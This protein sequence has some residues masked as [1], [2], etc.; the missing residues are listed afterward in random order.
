M[1]LP[2]RLIVVDS[3]PQFAAWAQPLANQG[4]TAPLPPL[5]L[6][7]LG[8]SPR[9]SPLQLAAD[10]GRLRAIL[11]VLARQPGWRL[12]LA[13]SEQQQLL[14]ILESRAGA[15]SA[16]A[17][18][19]LHFACING[20][21]K[22]PPS[23]GMG[24]PPKTLVLVEDDLLVRAVCRRFLQDRCLVLETGSAADALALAN[25]LPWPVDLLVSDVNL[26]LMDGVALARRWLE[27][28]PKC[29]VLLLSGS[30][31]PEGAATLPAVL[32]QKPFQGAELL[33][34]VGLLLGEGLA[35][36]A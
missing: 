17:A 36:S 12:R 20:A 1:N 8:V 6:A 24:A 23:P 22:D 21:D 26:P 2:C 16:P 15:V 30:F 13:L 14:A 10:S 31:F 35:A 32:L 19:L 11:P 25:W 28:Y 34:S 27:R 9:S 5:A 3:D 7:E 18:A 4:L 29:A 33:R